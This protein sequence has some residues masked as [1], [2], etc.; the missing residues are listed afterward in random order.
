MKISRYNYPAQ[1]GESGESLMQD[2]HSMVLNGPYILTKEVKQFEEAFAQFLGAKHVRGVNCGTDAL[3]IALLSL[4]VGIGHEVITQANGFHATTAAILLARAKPVLVDADDASFLIDETQIYAAI[5]SNTRAL[6]PVHLYGKPTPMTGLLQLAAKNGLLVVEDAAQAHGA[7]I[8]GRAVGTFGAVG[9][10]SFHP[11]K[12]LAA[13]GDGGALV[14][15]DSALADRIDLYR[16]LG[17]KAQNDHAVV[18][19]NSKLDAI[20]ARIL[21]HKLACLENWN[22][23]RRKIA[24][25][26]RERLAG[27]PVTVQKTTPGE[28]H[29]YHL[30][31]IRTIHRDK[32]LTH[33]QQHGVDVVVRYPTPIHLQPA[34]SECGWKRGQFPVAERLAEELLC[35]PI[36]PDMLLSDVDYVSDCVHS[37]FGSK[38]S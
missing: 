32:L 25:L 13:V 30:F 6:I 14:T 20:Q 21:S 15:D 26:Y 11:S 29:A 33:L 1:L 2:L 34:F 35:L 9:C 7:R 16:N 36:R 23:Q 4:G 3:I 17:Q 18:G 28:V 8:D 5:S 24:A 22:E 19:L 12:N 37:F 10:F 27:L 38:P 31:T